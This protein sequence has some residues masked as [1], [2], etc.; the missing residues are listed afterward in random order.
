MLNKKTLWALAA[1]LSLVMPSVARADAYYVA[2]ATWS[3]GGSA[4]K[5]LAFQNIST[6]QA[7]EIVKI[8]LSHATNGSAVT[9]GLAQFWV[10]ASTVMS[11]G[12]TSQTMGHSPK[13]ANT[14]L[15]SAIVSFSTG[16]ASVVY[17]NNSATKAALPLLEPLIVN[18][19]ETATSNFYDSW[20]APVYDFGGPKLSESILLPAGANRGI[21]IEQQNMAATSFTAGVV[22]ARIHYIVK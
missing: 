3:M 21:V 5:A 2:I 7:V 11:H 20:T 13:I 10:Y 15:P 18:G 22:Q 17:E 4:T 14:A 6:T 8:E 19:E 1:V 12:G 16:P 9:G